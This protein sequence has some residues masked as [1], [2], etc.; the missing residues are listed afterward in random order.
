MATKKVSQGT[1]ASQKRV[2]SPA[3]RGGAPG[4]RPVSDGIRRAAKRAG[5]EPAPD[6]TVAGQ[7]ELAS[8]RIVAASALAEFDAT[9]V[10]NNDTP[11]EILEQALLCVAGELDVVTDASSL[12]EKMIEPM[13]FVRLRR[14]IR[15]AIELADHRRQFGPFKDSAARSAAAGGAL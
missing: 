1:R 12:G 6:S 13:V 11:A 15:V 9:G 14:R 8:L 4:N 10:S 5:L 2:S 3:P 7:A